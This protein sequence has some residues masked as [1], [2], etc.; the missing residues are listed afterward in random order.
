MPLLPFTSKETAKPANDGAVDETAEVN[1]WFTD[2]SD[3][4][5]LPAL[6]RKQRLM[7]FM[8]FLVFGIVCF[9]LVNDDASHVKH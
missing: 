7:L 3:D 4:P 8:G 2:T 9:G 5:C 6:S 1:G